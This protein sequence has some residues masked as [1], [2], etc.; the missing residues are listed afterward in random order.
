MTKWCADRCAESSEALL[1]RF[2][3]AAGDNPDVALKIL[4]EDLEWREEMQTLSLASMTCDQ[5]LS[6]FK[7]PDTVKPMLED[8]LPHGFLG[9]DKIGRPVT[10]RFP[11]SSSLLSRTSP[12][13]FS[14]HTSASVCLRLFCEEMAQPPLPSLR[15]AL[16]FRF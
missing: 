5:A 10:Y 1:N 9:F 15:S 12:Q 2:L 13:S 14:I 6:Y 7:C 3:I 16:N 4:A 11:S 8:V